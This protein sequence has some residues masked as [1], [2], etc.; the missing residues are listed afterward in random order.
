MRDAYRGGMEKG[1]AMDE[2]ERFECFAVPPYAAAPAAE[3][4]AIFTRTRPAARLLSAYSEFLG[5]EAIPSPGLAE[6]ALPA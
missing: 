5:I 6:F 2:L 1:A 3:L 4:A